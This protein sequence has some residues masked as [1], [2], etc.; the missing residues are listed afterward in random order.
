M[1]SSSENFQASP[2]GER[3]N[4]RVWFASTSDTGGAG[5]AAVKTYTYLKGRLGKSI[6]SVLNKQSD[7]P[8]HG[9]P[10]DFFHSF[11]KKF[12]SLAEFILSERLVGNSG[13]FFSSG[14]FSSNMVREI[15]NSDVDL[16][17]LFWI[18]GYLSV[19]DLGKIQHPVVWRFSDLWPITYG[20]HY[21]ELLIRSG[22]WREYR[23]KL[24]RGLRTALDWKV[25]NLP[26]NL[27]VVCPS[28][29]L[30]D[31]VC[32]SE[33][34]E[35]NR[36]FYI[37]TGID[38]HSFYPID[39]RAAKVALGFLES[40]QLVLVGASAGDLDPR[41]GFFILREILKKLKK[42][43]PSVKVIGFGKS[44]TYDPDVLWLGPVGSQALL[45]LIMSA[46]DIYLNG[47]KNDNF[48]QTILES[49]SCGC[50]VVAFS[51]TGVAE[52]LYDGNC[53]ILLDPE[54]DPARI[55]DVLYSLLDDRYLLDFYSA[56]ARV[57]VMEAFTKDIYANRLINVYRAAL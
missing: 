45:R 35:R 17:Q 33:L 23:S 22:D 16:V 38:T 18:C 2:E 14:L 7:L 40:D 13:G 11:L 41:K 6:F 39:K 30:Y 27:R 1:S 37:P 3:N 43:R 24:S 19:W 51:H 53:G 28:R 15:N 8:N 26:K 32:S 10:P 56:Q 54:D 46:A 20:H 57:R 25:S 34:I 5:I 47:S 31:L 55:A 9:Y 42:I 48:P 29:W 50:P 52:A 4:L 21:D 12:R 36:I 49:M 44:A